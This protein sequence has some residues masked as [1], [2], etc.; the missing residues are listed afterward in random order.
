MTAK[1]LL[2]GLYG[3][4]TGQ[5]LANAINAD[6]PG[7]LPSKVLTATATYDP[8]SLATTVQDTIQTIAVTGAVVGN[9]VEATFSLDL[10]GLGL[11]A[12]VSTANT[13][14]FVFINTTAGTVD[15]GSG[16]VTVWVKQ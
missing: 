2:G 15:L 12:W 14:S 5:D 3:N 9:R 8:P 6:I 1:K 16:T 10:Q 13:V 4:L 11:R 7:A